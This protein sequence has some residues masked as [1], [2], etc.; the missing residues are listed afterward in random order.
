MLQAVGADEGEQDGE[1]EEAVE[2][3][4]HHHA[5][6]HLVGWGVCRYTTL[7]KVR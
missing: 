3:A 5:Y 4:E 7:K 6:K 2:E 1:E